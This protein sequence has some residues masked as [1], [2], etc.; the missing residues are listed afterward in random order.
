MA[1]RQK[2]TPP[3]GSY[4][5]HLARALRGPA[6]EADR[7]ESIQK[8]RA[9]LDRA[10]EEIAFS[11]RASGASWADIGEVFGITRQ[12]AHLRFR[13]TAGALDDLATA[14]GREVRP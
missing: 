1:K 4:A 5:W 14:R 2:T 9:R 12:G 6:L 3:T 11:L 13:D 7:V 8:L 10:E